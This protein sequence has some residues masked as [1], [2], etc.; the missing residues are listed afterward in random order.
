MKYIVV[1]ALL[2]ARLSFAFAQT[3][4]TDASAKTERVKVIKLAADSKPD[5]VPF[6]IGVTGIRIIPLCGDTAR[7]GY[8]Q[9]GMMNKK[10]SAVPDKPWANYLQ[11]FTDAQYKSMF[12]DTG[13][14]LLWVIKDLR[15]NERT[16]AMSEKAFV[17]LK[18]DAYA[19][20]DQQHYHLLA[21]FDTT[22]IRG[23]MDVTGKHD[24][25]IAQIVQ[26]LLEASVAN[27][28]AAV[29]DTAPLLAADIQD[30]TAAELNTSILLAT[31]YNS[32]VYRSYAEFLANTPSVSNFDIAIERKKVNVYETKADGSRVLVEHPWGLCK[33]GEV[34]KY[35]PTALI[36]LEKSGHAFVI[37]N[38]LEA[39]NRKNKSIFW[40]AVGGGLGGGLIG[41]AAMGAAA[42]SSA[43]N[44]VYLVTAIPYI[45]KQQPE[46]TTVDVE[47]GELMF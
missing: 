3:S 6:P 33:D 42:S 25:N 21:H 7:L 18:A 11:D 26:L 38:Y 46:A 5:L 36:P 23:G 37:S 9:V 16:F 8:V 4:A 12:K 47:S 15:I 39:I 44:S 32:G 31:Q 14:H 28:T 1:T 29:K 22:L 2:F 27:A 30:K 24:R 17:R 19:S 35:I 13:V 20:S 41:G 40:S 43:G 10:I 45:K 34:Y